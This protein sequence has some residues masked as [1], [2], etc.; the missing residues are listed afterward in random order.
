MHY[1]MLS[2]SLKFLL[3]YFRN[4]GIDEAGKVKT[5]AG[6]VPTAMPR[7]NLQNKHDYEDS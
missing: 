3:Y 2:S 5:R 4:D 6:P 7:F 1:F